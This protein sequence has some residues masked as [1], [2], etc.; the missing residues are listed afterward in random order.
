MLVWEYLAEEYTLIIHR[1]IW[2]QASTLCLQIIYYFIHL[3]SFAAKMHSLSFSDSFFHIQDRR[4][5]KSQ[6]SKTIANGT[7]EMKGNLFNHMHRTDP[8]VCSYRWFAFIFL[9]IWNYDEVMLFCPNIPW[10]H[11][12]VQVGSFHILRINASLAKSALR[13]KTSQGGLRRI[14]LASTGKKIPYA[15][16]LLYSHISQ[17]PPL[18]EP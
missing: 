11:L 13:V 16:I 2:I 7:T 12:T 1:H 3:C 4:K 18:N 15:C 17:L 6:K 9:K 14:N 8:N 5:Q 10:R